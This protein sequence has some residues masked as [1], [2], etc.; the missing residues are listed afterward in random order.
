MLAAGP[1]GPPRR[2][3]EPDD[4]ERV[5]RRAALAGRRRAPV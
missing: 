5:V 3:F 4:A 1:S 2:P